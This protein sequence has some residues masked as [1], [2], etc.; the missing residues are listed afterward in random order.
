M[1]IARRQRRAVSFLVA[2]GS[3]AVRARAGLANTLGATIYR[4]APAPGGWLAVE[5][6][7]R[8]DRPVPQVSADAE[9]AA[10]LRQVAATP[11]PRIAA[12]RGRLIFALDATASREPTW[13][14]ACQIQSEMFAETAAIGGLDIQLCFF[15]GF[16]EFRAAPWLADSAVLVRQMTAVRC[17][18]GHTQIAKVLRHAIAETG[19]QKVN[20]L[21]YVGDC[22]EEDAETLAGLA[23]ELGLLGVPAFVFQEGHEPAAR[24]SFQQIARLSNGAYSSFDA[25]SAKQLRDL[26]SA[27]AVYA[28]GGRTALADF[29]K[30]SGAPVLQLAR[31]L[32]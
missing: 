23:G 15:R 29:A 28:A 31:Q 21:V 9:V 18:G 11:A 20:A 8:D 26:L 17:R 5:S 30:R 25:G 12:K 14:R 13:D 7:G 2:I 22:M 10:F 6:M 24:A 3:R 19:R 4:L 16:G 32:R 27:V 1:R